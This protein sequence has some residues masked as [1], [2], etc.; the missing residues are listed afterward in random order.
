MLAFYLNEMAHIYSSCVNI[1]WSK[2]ISCKNQTV[3][4]TIIN[5]LV[6]TKSSIVSLETELN[7]NYNTFI[8]LFI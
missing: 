4:G 2:I 1:K 7:I 5:K 6:G 8:L 3:P